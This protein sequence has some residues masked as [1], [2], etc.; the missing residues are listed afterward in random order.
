MLHWPNRVS[1]RRCNTSTLCTEKVY[2]QQHCPLHFSTDYVTHHR[3][4]SP[5]HNMTRRVAH[6]TTYEGRSYVLITHSTCW[7]RRGATRSVCSLRPYIAQKQWDCRVQSAQ[8]LTHHIRIHHVVV[9][10]HI[11]PVSVGVSI[12]RRED[13]GHCAVGAKVL[14]A[15]CFEC[16]VLTSRVSVIEHFAHSQVSSTRH[17]GLSGVMPGHQ[18]QVRV[19][20]K[21]SG[22]KVSDVIIVSIGMDN[23]NHLRTS[24]SLSPPGHNI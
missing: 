24:D 13:P 20:Q 19:T 23:K 21:G 14:L 16:L 7:G 1:S 5:S 10:Q 8:N 6:R 4:L 11:D 15:L 9:V 17:S 22:H 2:Q 18:D 3:S 12:H